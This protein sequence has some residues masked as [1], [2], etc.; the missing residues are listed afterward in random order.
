[1]KLKMYFILLAMGLFSFGL[2]SCDDDDDDAAAADQIE[3]AFIG[4]FGKVDHRWDN[5]GAYKVASFTENKT[6]K[7]AWFDANGVWLMT[8][9]DLPYD[10]LPQPVQN[11]FDK[12]IKSKY[13]G[14]TRDDVDMLERKDRETVYVIEIK[15]G[16]EE[17]DLYFDKNGNLLKEVA[18]KEN[19]SEDYLENTAIPG[20]IVK[21]LGEKYNGYTLLEV[22]VDA[23]KPGI[24][25]FDILFKNKPLEV[26]FKKDDKGHYQWESTSQDIL[27]SELPK[28]VKDA[29]KQEETKHVG[30]ELD[31]DD[32]EKVETPKGIY[33]V[34]ELENDATKEEIEVKIKA[35]G[36][37]IQ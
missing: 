12:L 31:E 8:E 13:Q 35:D 34:V 19:D 3:T 26:V 9:T 7:E 15:K 23:K 32:A 25:E 21:V 24:M 28:E 20:E 30:F 37:V 22:D 36:T 4:K 18:D 14:W 2:Q 1:M 17:F 5:H 33:Y 6:E 16:M 11:A 29:A 27:F 10:Q